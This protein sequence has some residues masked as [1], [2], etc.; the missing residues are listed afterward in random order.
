[1]SS[2]KGKVIFID[3]VHPV[4][5]DMLLEQGYECV[6]KIHTSKEEILKQISDYQGIV[7]RSRFKIT[8]EILDLCTNLKFIARSGSGLENIDTTYA[9]QKGILCFNSPEGNRDAVAEHALGMLLCLFNKIHLASQEVKNGVWIREGNRGI[10]LKN[11][12]IGL[13]GYGIMGEAFAKRLAGFGVKVIAY[14]KFKTGFNS[15]LVKEVSLDELKKESD[16][17]SLHVNYLPE[18]EYL[19]DSH[20]IAGFHKNI[21]LIN[22]ARGKCVKTID[23]IQALKSGKVLGA[24]LDVLEFEAVSFETLNSKQKTLNELLAFPNVIVTPHIAGWT[25]ESYVKLSS[26][27]G[28]KIKASF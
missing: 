9:N 2:N 19:I 28:E 4:L 20:F 18:N 27:L 24:C 21:Y 8:S 11:K 23:L 7:I 10:E 12:T 13:I 22:T 26:F 6:D 16:V 5:K 1:M 14:D 15:D 3:E 25:Q 17:V